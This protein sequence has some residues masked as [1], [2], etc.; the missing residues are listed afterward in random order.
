[1]KKL[2]KVLCLAAAVA[3]FVTLPS[4]AVKNKGKTVMSLGNA[5]ITDRMY[6]YWTSNYKADFI[7]AYSDVS[8]TAEFWDSVLYDGVTAEKYLSERIYESI[9]ADLV[10]MYLFNEYRLSVPD[11]YK[12][13]ADNIISD[14]MDYYDADK[15]EFNRLLSQYGINIDL[16][17]EIMIDEAKTTEVYNYLFEN[18]IL[19]VGDAEK[20]EY[21]E[22]NYSR[23]L[24]IYINNAYDSEKS[25][26]DEN[27][28]FVKAE[29]D[30]ETKAKK[31]AQVQEALDALDRGEN[32]TDV[33]MKYSDETSYPNG[34][35]IYA[36]IEGLPSELVTHALSL[37]VGKT[38]VFDSYYGAH[39]IK[40]VE[41]D[42]KPWENDENSDFFEDFTDSVYESVYIEHISSYYDMIETDDEAIAAI[43]V[44]DALP[45][46]SFRY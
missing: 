30:S 22:K 12:E 3:L 45:N 25:D 8:D 36:G 38:E 19:T 18:N 11:E 46:Y 20:Q 27:G 28:N 14:L 44:K 13:A 7:S 16:L 37:E 42:E 6:G 41:M 17:R 9:R 34:Y 40:R 5:E 29:L 24:H 2:L 31:D 21:V 35:Y 26:Y 23:V 10:G 39:I 32:F 33:Y 4:C 1:M 43:S 15:N